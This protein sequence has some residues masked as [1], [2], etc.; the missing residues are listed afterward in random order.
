MRSSHILVAALILAAAST[1]AAQE[2][3]EKPKPPRA[4]GTTKP[5]EPAQGQGQQAQGNASQGNTPLGGSVSAFITPDGRVLAN[6]GYG[7]ETVSSYCS[8]S[9][10]PT[11]NATPNSQG[12]PPVPDQQT[13]SARNLPS[14]R[15]KQANDAQRQNGARGCIARDGDRLYVLRY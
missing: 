6:F 5:A 2:R 15:A 13:E 12:L 9:G 4:R 14:A 10:T 7:Y 3:F 11:V 8:N 1:A